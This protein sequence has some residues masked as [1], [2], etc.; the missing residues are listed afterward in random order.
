MKRGE[1][2]YYEDATGRTV[3]KIDLIHHASVSYKSWVNGAWSKTVQQS[4]KYSFDTYYHKMTKQE[5]IKW[6]LKNE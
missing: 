6:T 2:Y 5:H 1:L 4:S 3:I